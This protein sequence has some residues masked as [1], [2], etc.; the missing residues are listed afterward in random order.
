MSKS[1]LILSISFIVNLFFC[2]LTYSSNAEQFDFNENIEKYSKLLK[3]EPKNCFYIEQIASSYQALNNFRDAII[4][5]EKALRYCSDNSINRFQ[6]GVCHYLIMER[7]IAVSLMDQA[8]E[9]AKNSGENAMATMLKNEKKAW[10][11]KWNQ[12]KELEWNKK[13]DNKTTASEE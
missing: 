9:E 7:E 10:S 4:F 1:K 13:N 6:L 2:L 3:K 12:V 5:Y 8:I 11:E